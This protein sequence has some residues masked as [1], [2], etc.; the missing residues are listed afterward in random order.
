MVDAT[1]G[2][3]NGIVDALR[4]ND[5]SGAQGREK[6][7]RTDDAV[8]LYGGTMAASSRFVV[9][10]EVVAEPGDGG[11]SAVSETPT[12][13]VLGGVVDSGDQ[14]QVMSP[15]IG[16]GEHSQGWLADQ[17]NA[18]TSSQDVRQRE[19]VFQGLGM[20]GGRMMQEQRADGSVRTMME[21]TRHEQQFVEL[22]ELSRLTIGE[23][24]QQNLTVGNEVHTL[25][26]GLETV[27]SH[28]KAAFEQL[29]QRLVS[30]DED[31]RRAVE[32]IV[33]Y[34]EDGRKGH[35]SLE[36]YIESRV[37]SRFRE[38]EKQREDLE[39]FKS[40]WNDIVDKT[41]AQGKAF[42]EYH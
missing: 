15:N 8:H 5:D 11:G 6:V 28:V 27:V 13:V 30:R 33:D 21:W 36:H 31:V 26:S 2:A 25:A 37:V 41:R 42:A 35:Q 9:V 10:P 12:A 19:S 40:R 3:T 14:R 4:D 16:E 23:L 24:L 29:N 22:T 34:I 38:L 1:N 39:D 7:P 17:L 32:S 18:Q 20:G